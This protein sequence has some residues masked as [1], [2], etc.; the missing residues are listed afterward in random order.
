MATAMITILYD[1]C[2]FCLFNGAYL[3]YGLLV[4]AVSVS[5]SIANSTNNRDAE[6]ARGRL[7]P[8]PGGELQYPTSRPPPKTFIVTDIVVLLL[9]YANFPFFIRLVKYSIRFI[10]AIFLMRDNPTPLQSFWRYFNIYYLVI[11]LPAA[12]MPPVLHAQ[13]TPDFHL[14][15]A[16]VLLICVNALGDMVSVRLTLA[17]FR[18]FGSAPTR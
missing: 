11:V 9:G 2:K 3:I 13:R 7:P 17:S 16:V 14:L 1:V 6:A 15:A 8:M 4:F 12:F 18:K 5:A 10:R